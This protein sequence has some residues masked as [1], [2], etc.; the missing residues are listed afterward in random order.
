MTVRSTAKSTVKVT[1]DGNLGLAVKR[2]FAFCLGKAA[3]APKPNRPATVG[4]GDSWLRRTR[5]IT[6]YGMYTMPPLDSTVVLKSLANK[7]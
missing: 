6:N 5:T 7:G 1:L 3:L 2:L 4:V